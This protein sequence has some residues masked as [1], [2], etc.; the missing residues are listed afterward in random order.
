MR[1][2]TNAGSARLRAPW[3]ERARAICREW[4][5]R[6]RHVLGSDAVPIRPER[7]CHELTR[8]VPDDAIV[9]VDTGHA[10]MWMGGMFDL[11]KPN[12]G[13]IRS[14]GHLGWAFSAGLGA[15]CAAP[16]RPVVVFTGD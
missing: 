15:K 1:E 9:V 7:L 16:E 12:Q 8:T 4:Q 13:Y 14:A 2:H 5:D 11:T 10:G 6:Y 3:V